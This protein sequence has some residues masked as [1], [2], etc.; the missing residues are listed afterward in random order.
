[1]KTVSTRGKYLTVLTV[2]CICLFILL[3]QVGMFNK[4]TKPIKEYNRFEE[5]QENKTGLEGVHL[6]H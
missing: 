3:Y 5:E 2:F 4:V 1:M 6:L